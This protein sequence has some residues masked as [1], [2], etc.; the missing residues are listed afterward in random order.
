MLDGLLE[1]KLDSLTGKD[2]LVIMDDGLGFLGKLE[3]Y[4]KK[5][6]VLK[7]VLQSQFDDIDWKK[8]ATDSRDVR[9]K[10]NK[11]KKIGFANWTRVNLEEVYIRIE[12]ITRIWP[13]IQKERVKGETEEGKRPIYYEKEYL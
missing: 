1:K 8:I 9:K 7:K 12:H 11:E 4:D 3:E 13:W 6:I 5:T 10:K 2:I